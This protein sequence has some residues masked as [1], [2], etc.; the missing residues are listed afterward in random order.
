MSRSINRVVFYFPF[1]NSNSIDA[2]TCAKYREEVH[3]IEI[4]KDEIRYCLK[5]DDSLFYIKILDI[6]IVYIEKKMEFDINFTIQYVD[7]E[8]M[9]KMRCFELMQLLYNIKAS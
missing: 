1:T 6:E 7:G 2:L 5:E 4:E 9:L 3:F 8:G